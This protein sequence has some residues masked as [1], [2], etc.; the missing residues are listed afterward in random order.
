[1]YAV[2]WY[3][4]PRAGLAASTTSH[5]PPS[6]STPILSPGF[7]AKVCPSFCQAKVGRG[8]PVAL[9]VSAKL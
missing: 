6:P 3:Q 7:G 8:T 9:A 2:S 4:P 5:A 1:L